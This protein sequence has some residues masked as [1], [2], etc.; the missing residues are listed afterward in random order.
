[1]RNLAL[2]FASIFLVS[3]AVPKTTRLSKDL[4]EISG[5]VFAN[6]TTLIAHN[7]SGNDPKLFVLN[8]DGSIRNKVTILNADNIDF[9]DITLDQKGN[10]YVGDFGN[11]KNQRT[12]L[13]ILKVSLK[14]VLNNENVEAKFIDFS[15]PEQTGFPPKLNQKYF[16]CEAMSFYNDS[17]YLFTKCRTEPFDGK[18]FVYTL[19]TNPGTYKATKKYYI[20]IGKRDWLRDAVTAADIHDG[21]LYILTYN[22]FITYTFENGKAKYKSHQTLFPITQKESLA[23]HSSG[24]IYIADERQ[25]LVG[26]GNMYV[27]KPTEKRQ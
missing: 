2:F 20:V 11:N 4:K 25:K 24:K 21:K 9:E 26:G 14:K 23:V 19:P 16:D 8:L 6:D 18:C 15:Y 13:R 3:A 5:W 7:D 17:L 27:I 22:R 10:L 12:N 1:M